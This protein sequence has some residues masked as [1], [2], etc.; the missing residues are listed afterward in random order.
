MKNFGEIKRILLITLSNAGDVILTS[1]LV[2]ALL[3][4]FPGVKL[5]IVV[6]PN[7]R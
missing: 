5:D 2:E 6:G 7:G 3:K 4:E 1:S